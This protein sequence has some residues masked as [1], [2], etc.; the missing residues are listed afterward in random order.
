MSNKFLNLIFLIATLHITG[1]IS[2]SAPLAV[3]EA[4]P[5]TSIPTDIFAALQANTSLVIPQHVTLLIPLQGPLADTGQAIRDGFMLAYQMAPVAARPATINVIDSSNAAEIKA[6]YELAIQQG[7][8]FI[9]GPLAKVNVQS[10]AQINNLSVPT[11]ALNYVDQEQSTPAQFYQFGLS[12][13]DEVRQVVML[14]HQANKQ[15]AIIMVPEGGWGQ[16]IAQAF[17]D[18]WEKQ[19]GKVRTILALSSAQAELVQQIKQ[20][21]IQ[22][23]G[24]FDVVLLAAAPTVARQIKPLFKFY[25][26]DD[27]AI[28]A[29]SMIYNATPQA[30]LNNDLN[31]VIFCDAPWA[32][33]SQPESELYQ[34]LATTYPA[35]F[36]N[37][38]KYYGLGV[39][40][41]RIALQL[42][43][44]LQA[45][46]T[47]TGTTGSLTFNAQNRIV[48]TLPCAQF[49][50]GVPVLLSSQ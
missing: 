45:Q 10:V 27:M 3:P 43:T 13:F 40:A 18:E 28:Y 25:H 22:Q 24:K 44:M 17:Q 30:Q 38:A 23:R 21:A 35:N 4:V 48:R 33:S 9:I 19:G 11:L 37:R 1:C 20:L 26:I 7:A 49:K 29:T 6:N 36:Q 31:G 2:I 50:S 46:L 39:D 34:K 14:A 15:N 41:Y 42:N 12:P 5:V 32:L 47:L 16:T 8:N